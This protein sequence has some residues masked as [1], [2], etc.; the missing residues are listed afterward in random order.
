LRVSFFTHQLKKM[1]RQLNFSWDRI[2]H[3][4]NQWVVNYNTQRQQDFLSRMFANMGFGNIDWREMISLLVAGMTLVT[5]VVA[6]YLLR[7]WRQLNRDPAQVAYERFCQ[8]LSRRGIQR[9][10]AEG[11]L[12]FALRAGRQYPQQARDINHIT[13]LY[14]RQRYAAYPTQGNLHRLQRAVRDFNMN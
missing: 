10:S 11:P 12:D 14:E 7:P 1:G 3:A 6:V 2:N 13:A 5:A 8:R 4:W 9:Q